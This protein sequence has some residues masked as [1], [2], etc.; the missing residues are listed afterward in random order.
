MPRIA[1][2][3]SSSAVHACIHTHART[4]THKGGGGGG[5]GGGGEGGGEGVGGGGGGG[6]GTCAEAMH[7]ELVG[8]ALPVKHAELSSNVGELPTRISKPSSLC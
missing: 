8:V 6:G 1:S 5:E 2:L 3:V 7:D 4:H